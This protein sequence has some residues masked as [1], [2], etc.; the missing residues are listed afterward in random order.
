MLVND[1]F[2]ELFD[3]AARASRR[4]GV[5]LYDGDS[6]SATAGRQGTR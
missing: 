2:L 6:S 5:R 1:R 3:G 4:P